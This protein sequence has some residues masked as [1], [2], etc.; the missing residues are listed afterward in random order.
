MNRKNLLFFLFVVLPSI[1]AAA[2]VAVIFLTMMVAMHCV[3]A[4]P[5]EAMPIP[6][7]TAAP[8]LEAGVIGMG[9]LALDVGYL[10][11][12]EFW[13]HGWGEDTGAF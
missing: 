11:V 13:R 12:A 4:C 6:A 10:L 2:A 9:V 7:A 3:G 5:P 8:I 1:P